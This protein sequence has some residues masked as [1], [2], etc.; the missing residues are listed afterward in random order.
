[1]GSVLPKNLFLGIALKIVSIVVL[2]LKIG[3]KI[4]S[5]KQRVTQSKA[6]H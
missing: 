4:V 1:M 2:H 3:V 5:Q 6:S